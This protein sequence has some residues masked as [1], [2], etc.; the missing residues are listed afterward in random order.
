M[1]IREKLKLEF[2]NETEE[3]IQFI[4]NDKI[5]NNIHIAFICGS[6]GEKLRYYTRNFSGLIYNTT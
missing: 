6:E 5:K 2:P 1:S 3:Q 4:F